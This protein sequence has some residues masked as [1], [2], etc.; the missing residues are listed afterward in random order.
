MYIDDDIQAND[1]VQTLSCYDD[2]SATAD[3]NVLYY[4]VTNQTPTPAWG[5]FLARTSGTSNTG[6]NI[7]VSAI[8]DLESHATDFFEL[9]VTV[10]DQNNAGSDILTVNSDLTMFVYVR[11]INNDDPIITSPASPS[12]INFQ[13]RECCSAATLVQTITISDN[14]F[15]HATSNV[16]FTGQITSGNSGNTFR[17]LSNANWNE[18]ELHIAKSVDRETTSSYELVIKVF[19]EPDYQGTQKTATL[20][21]TVD[22]TDANDNNLLCN[23]SE[24]SVT[25][26]ETFTGATGTFLPCSDVDTTGTMV[27]SLTSGTPADFATYFSFITG[28]STHTL[29]LN[30]LSAVNY[31]VNGNHSYQLVGGVTDGTHRS[32]EVTVHVQVR[33]FTMRL[34]LVFLLWNFSIILNLLNLISL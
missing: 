27:A 21:L 9:T 31:N 16:P 13:E 30:V 32:Q 23:P 33:F 26:S 8:V 29:Q 22:I 3:N 15:T 1:V 5:N 11:D 18:I 2:D 7:E 28:P 4:E 24:I 25:I 14:D 17:L 12:S 10:K 34:Y 6:P 20:S 19:D